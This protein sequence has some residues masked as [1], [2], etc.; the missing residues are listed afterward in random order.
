MHTNH[1]KRFSFLKKTSLQYTY[2]KVGKNL[3]IFPRSQEQLRRNFD[4]FIGRKALQVGA[5]TR[6]GK[7]FVVLDMPISHMGAL[8]LKWSSRK[9]RRGK[10]RNVKN[11]TG[12]RVRVGVGAPCSI[13][14]I[15]LADLTVLQA[16]RHP[17]TPDV[18]YI[19]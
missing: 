10:K 12:P 14:G 11:I 1:K 16:A 18:T 4:I 17:S 6:E 5:F 9:P 2:L 8:L 15:P 19:F 13:P 3:K 7:K